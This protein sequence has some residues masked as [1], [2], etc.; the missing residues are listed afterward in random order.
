MG[1]APK[2]K[3]VVCLRGG[4]GAA[5]ETEVPVVIASTDDRWSPGRTLRPF[6]VAVGAAEGFAHETIIDCRWPYTL[7]K[8]RLPQTAVFCLP[9]STME[10]VTIALIPGLQMKGPPRPPAVTSPAVAP[11]PPP[12]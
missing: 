9:P 3:Y 6:E 7:E 10:K 12:V 2:D 1:V 4:P 11:P 8:S 5:S